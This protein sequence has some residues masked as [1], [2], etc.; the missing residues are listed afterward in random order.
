MANFLGFIKQRWFIS[1][2][3][4]IA[5]CLFVWF[6]GPLFAF[7]G[8]SPLEAVVNRWFLIGMIWLLWFVI[9]VWGF[10][11][12]RKQNTQ[13]MTAMLGQ[14]EP[15]LDPDEQASQ[16]ELETLRKRL[17]DALETLKKTRLGRGSKHQLLYQLPWYIIIGPPGSGKTTLLKNSD[18]KFPLS[19]RYGK[20]S[21]RGVGGTRNCDWWFTDDAVLLDTAGRYTTQ[22]S[23]EKVDQ[24]AWLGFLDLLK[25]YRKRR[26]ISGVIIAVSI[27]DLL[28]QSSEERLRQAT[29]IRNRINELYTHFNIRFP[30]YLLFTKC[31]LLAGFMEYFDDFSSQ[32]RAQVWGVTFPFDEQD[33]QDVLHQFKSEFL[34]LQQQLQKQLLDKLERE[35]SAERRNLIYTF[36]QQ[37]SSLNAV[38][39]PFLE[40]LFLQSRYSHPPMF[41]GVY[42][43][44]AT[45]EGSPID[46]IMGTLS[47]NFGL[48]N[49]VPSSARGQGK[50][51]FINRLLQAVIFSES[52]L[53]GINMKLE[54]KRFWFQRGAFVAVVASVILMLGLWSVSYYKNKA[55]I[56]EVSAQASHL[57][58]DIGDIDSEQENVL[59][60]LPILDKARDIPGGYND[61][62]N[63]DIPWSQTFGLY[64]G[65]KLGEAAVSLYQKLLRNVFL[66]RLLARLEFALQNNT[67]KPEYLYEALRVYLML[68]EPEHYDPDAIANWFRLDWKYN[69][70]LDVTAAQRDSLNNHLAALLTIGT[71]PL[72]RPIDSVLVQQTRI[73]L[74]EIPLADRVY[75]RLKIELN[76]GDVD[77]FAVSEK[78]GRDAPLV[79]SSK[80]GKPL[81]TGVPALFTCEGYKTLFMPNVDRFIN[82]QARDNWIFGIKQQ[83]Q[84]SK[85]EVSALE[86]N[87]KKLYFQD[88]NQHW[89][90]L[91]EDIQIKPF[92][93]QVQMVEMLN[94]ISGDH[95]PVKLF[96][97]AVDQETS[98]SCLHKKDDSLL[99][100]AGA[101]LD[102]A[103]LSLDRIM[104]A[105]PEETAT[106]APEIGTNLVTDHFKGLHQMLETTDGAPP[107]IDRTLSVL[108]ELYVYLNSLV[109]ASGDELVLEQRKQIVQVLEKVKM[110]GKRTPFPVSGMLKNIAEGSGDL[111]SGGVRKYLNAMWRSTVLPFCQKAIQGLYPIK[112]SSRREITYEDFTYFFGPGGLMDSFYKKYLVSNVDVGGR[113]WRWNTRGNGE[114]GL[115]V[116]ALKQ[117]Q[118]ADNIKNIFFRMGRQA[119]S[120]RFKLKP[121]SMSPSIVQ[122]V[123]DIDGQTL[124]YAHGPLR[125]VAMKWPGPDNSG[126]V[127]LQFLPP[128]QGY[129]GLS[130]DGPWALFRVFDEARIS[131]TSNPTVFIITFNI[132]GREAKLELQASS[133][134][135]PFQLNDLQSFR[136]LQ[137]L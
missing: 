117:F 100:K 131:R 82:Q 19:D 129:S 73:I 81:T 135:N 116:A 136:C 40:E 12:A 122:M 111:V 56:R 13:F 10:V 110:E 7:A 78:A 112:K 83:Q 104:R 43:T 46:R 57:K 52:G 93:S 87:V 49:P 45:Q 16:E 53:A 77:D 15:A 20:D 97:L 26:P 109:H 54:K 105:K 128:L 60:V 98:M 85:A 37:F 39:T 18:L 74:E 127:R 86:D 8:Y 30:V 58:S 41:R 68:A 23:N 132:Q 44:S 120:I 42:F 38:I 124:T 22:D 96:L 27:A 121:I 89:D 33:N 115:S 102:N 61:Q 114:P 3:G 99:A 47:R 123:L 94:I 108:N 55:Y 72:P 133:A 50:S 31:D 2:L 62:Q 29:A 24:T 91:L 28:Q 106:V 64:Q 137:N 70:P 125:P 32:E 21:I 25:K 14:D 88:Y 65:D 67:N 1:L 130:K 34:L 134:V 101:K 76:G 63:G 95:S 75:S 69:L 36:P 9:L 90:D 126:Q 84:L 5:I 92:T 71:T 35:R 66:P 107:P 51:F 103:R 118:R 113:T 119:P 79:L 4:I 11:K 48:D 80:S 17:Q 59:A 6:V